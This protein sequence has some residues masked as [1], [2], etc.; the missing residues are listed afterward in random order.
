M[1]SIVILGSIGIG[2]VIGW[3]FGILEPRRKLF[4]QI[5]AVG[6]AGLLVLLDV[7]WQAGWQAALITLGSGFIAYLVHKLWRK[8][9]R[10]R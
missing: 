5:L 4:S 2:A 1:S 9:L 3:L 10:E 7:T 8:E 6:M